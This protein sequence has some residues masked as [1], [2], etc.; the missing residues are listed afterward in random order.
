MADFD[1][2][3]KLQ[4]RGEVAPLRRRP[5]AGVNR[6]LPISLGR[7]DRC[8][9]PPHEQFCGTPQF[10]SPREV[11]DKFPQGND[12]LCTTVE[13]AYPHRTVDS[14]VQMTGLQSQTDVIASEMALQMGSICWFLIAANSCLTTTEQ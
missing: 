6:T 8:W 1:H 2:F 13:S 9:T 4:A 10:G 7:A 12:H 11:L 5:A 14:V 3:A